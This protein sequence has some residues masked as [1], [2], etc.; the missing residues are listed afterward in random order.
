MK[1]KVIVPDFNEYKQYNIRVRKGAA[2]YEFF[3]A[4]I[5]GVLA[6]SPIAA[7]HVDL[8][9]R[10]ISEINPKDIPLEL[11]ERLLFSEV[12]RLE[13]DEDEIPPIIVT[14]DTS[15][16]ILR[17]NTE[18]GIEHADLVCVVGSLMQDPYSFMRGMVDQCPEELWTLLEYIYSDETPAVSRAVVQSHPVAMPMAV[19]AG[20]TEDGLC[21]FGSLVN[22]QEKLYL[23]IT[24]ST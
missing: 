9:A 19:T 2:E 15:V 17:R 13:R 20:V 11:K 14:T 16:Q 3:N 8:S 22:L 24:M 12:T 6:K 10:K 1:T 7:M 21:R 5:L 18:T 23:C 4:F